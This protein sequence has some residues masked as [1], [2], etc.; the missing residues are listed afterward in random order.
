MI[1]CLK[2]KFYDLKK[3]IFITFLEILVTAFN[4]MLML[5]MPCSSFYAAA[6]DFKHENV[7]RI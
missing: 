2:N 3:I 6:G 7:T 1:F 4:M 5:L